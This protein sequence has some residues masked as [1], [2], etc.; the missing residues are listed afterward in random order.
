MAF[1]FVERIAW[2]FVSTGWLPFLMVAFPVSMTVQKINRLTLAD[3]KGFFGKLGT[4]SLV[5]GPPLRM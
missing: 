1:S 5:N 3:H 2:L 4:C